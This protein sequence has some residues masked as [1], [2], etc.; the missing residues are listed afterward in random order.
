[1]DKCQF[2][3]RHL[4]NWFC[5]THGKFAPNGLCPLREFNREKG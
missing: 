3:D 5:V 2:V 1:M 4:V